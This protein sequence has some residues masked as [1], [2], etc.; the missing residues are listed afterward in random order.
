MLFIQQ[1]QQC[2]VGAIEAANGE[3]LVVGL[4][5]TPSTSS[6]LRL[7]NLLVES[8][9]VEIRAFDEFDW[10]LVP[11]HNS[12]VGWL[13]PPLTDALNVE[14][15]SSE[16]LFR[17]RSCPKVAACKNTVRKW[18]H[19]IKEKLRRAFFAKMFGTKL[20]AERTTLP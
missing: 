8:K 15:L 3:H 10:I 2:G 12:C 19:P 9:M 1:V 5:V 18:I 6:L 4:L 17:G 14:E 7:P 20:L 11:V 13:L 16:L